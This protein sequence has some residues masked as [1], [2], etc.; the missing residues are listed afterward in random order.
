MSGAHPAPLAATITFG[1]EV[2]DAIA[3]H[4]ATLLAGRPQPESTD[5]LNLEAAALYLNWPNK[6]LY[7]LVAK[8]E[9]PHRKQGNRLLFNRQELDRWLD[10]YYQ[11]PAEFAA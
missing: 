2:I 4:V 5:W 1:Q 10:S 8:N 7:N 6:R 11:G 3:E 9:I